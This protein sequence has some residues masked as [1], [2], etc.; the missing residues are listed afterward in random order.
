[1]AEASTVHQSNVTS[2][3]NVSESVGV[4]RSI[5]VAPFPSATEA[6]ATASVAGGKAEED[7]EDPDNPDAFLCGVDAL[8]SLDDGQ[9]PVLFS[10]PWKYAPSLE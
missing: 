10:N 8:Q 7:I 4:N 3:W 2:S 1:M 6:S 5:V 9:D